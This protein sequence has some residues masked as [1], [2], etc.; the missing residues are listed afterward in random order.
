MDA[1][2]A[3]LEDNA[4]RCAQ[5]AAC[6][7]QIA[8]RLSPI[9]FESA[10]EMVAWLRDHQGEVVLLSLDYD[11]PIRRTADGELQDFGTG[12][13][14]SAFLC[15]G[16]PTCP[17]IVHSSNPIGAAKMVQQLEAARWPVVRVYP[18][19]DTQWIDECWAAEIGRFI[20]AGLLPIS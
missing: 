14:V 3:I 16:D 13:T 18:F 6:L 12:E 11:L 10:H 17:V 8:P 7:A 20:S 15:A 19:E 4:A 5:M 1:Y 9:C 2:I